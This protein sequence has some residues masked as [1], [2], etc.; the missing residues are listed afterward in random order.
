MSGDAQ[1]THGSGVVQ[2]DGYQPGARAVYPFGRGVGVQAVVA[3]PIPPPPVERKA[4]Q[5]RR[6]REA[7]HFHNP[8]K[9]G[10]KVGSKSRPP[11]TEDML[12]GPP[13]EGQPV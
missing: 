4:S 13:D 7:E 9:R 6:Q 3:T 2:A 12:N 11:L 1:H 10:R 5:E 8:P